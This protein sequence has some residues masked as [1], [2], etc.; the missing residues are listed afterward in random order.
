M[1]RFTSVVGEA[2]YAAITGVDWPMALS[3]FPRRRKVE[4]FNSG[5]RLAACS[6]MM[7][8]LA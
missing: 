8:A 7:L 4:N 2:T 1:A 3:K 5:L 6:M